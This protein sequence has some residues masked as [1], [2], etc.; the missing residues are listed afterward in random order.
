M[1]LKIAVLLCLVLLSFNHTSGQTIHISSPPIQFDDGSSFRLVSEEG[2]ISNIVYKRGKD[3]SEDFIYYI[4]ILV[5]ANLTLYGN[6][7]FILSTKI[8]ST[9]KANLGNSIREYD[10]LTVETYL[11]SDENVSE[12]ISSL[13]QIVKVFRPKYSSINVSEITTSQFYYQF[14]LGD[15]DFK[16]NPIV[17]I[18]CRIEYHENNT[19]S[20]QNLLTQELSKG[21]LIIETYEGNYP[22][23]VVSILIGI[24]IIKRLKSIDHKK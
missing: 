17:S 6:S 3:G 23:M 9:H 13:N 20:S 12:H 2:K 4:D 11:S 8:Q 24:M 19:I 22:F 21:M 10:N 14:N 16:D 7:S 15:T 18:D 1:K 5:F